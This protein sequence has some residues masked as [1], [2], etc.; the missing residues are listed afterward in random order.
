ME[1]QRYLSIEEKIEE[2]RT[3][4]E[5]W[6][7]R[8]RRDGRVRDLLARLER[9]TGASMQAMRVL[10][11]VQACK[12]CEEQ[13]GGSCCG[14]GIENRYDPV[15]L[16]INLL[17]DVSLPDRQKYPD[18]CYFLESDGCRLKARH[19]LCVNYLCKKL[20]ETLSKDELNTLQAIVGEELDT[21]FALHE[22]VKKQVARKTGDR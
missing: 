21:G 10:R 16:L 14:A 17:L 8:L 18:S 12:W 2:A 19:V 5:A 1:A 13:E 6:A 15:Q 4:Y 11:V 7:D 9:N 22:A 3:L 20:R